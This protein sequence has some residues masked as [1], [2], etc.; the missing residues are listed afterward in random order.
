[1]TRM[2][3]GAGLATI[4]SQA[5]RSTP[6]TAGLAGVNSAATPATMDSG[7]DLCTGHIESK[8]GMRDHRDEY[9]T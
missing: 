3:W 2:A 4:D 8:L 7:G 9:A 1:M 5:T 6:G